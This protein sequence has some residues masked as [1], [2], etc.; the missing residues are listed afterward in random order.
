MVANSRCFFRNSVFCPEALGL[1]VC[2]DGAARRG[3]GLVIA[4]R[5]PASLV[6]SLF[7]LASDRATRRC[8]SRGEFLAPRPSPPRYNGQRETTMATSSTPSPGYDEDDDDDAE[9][10]R[11]RELDDHYDDLREDW[12]E[13]AWEEQGH[14]AAALGAMDK[15]SVLAELGESRNGLDVPLWNIADHLR[16]DVTVAV[17]MA[18]SGGYECVDETAQTNREVLRAAID[19]CDWSLGKDDEYGRE[20]CKYTAVRRAELVDA[21]RAQNLFFLRR[22]APLLGRVALVLRGLQEDSLRPGGCGFKRARGACVARGM[23]P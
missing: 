23:E 22:K 2:S 18:R 19:Q 15:E 8:D 7:T 5:R 14:Y 4:A 17:A 6:S 1:V 13:R 11:R 10:R 9:E 20:H 21:L 3:L 16:A 12:E